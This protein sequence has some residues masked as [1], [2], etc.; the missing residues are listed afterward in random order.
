MNKENR[1]QSGRV[2]TLK[3]TDVSTVAP[4]LLNP[5]RQKGGA[6]SVDEIGIDMP[7]V[8]TQGHGAGKSCRMYD[9]AGGRGSSPTGKAAGFIQ[10]HHPGVVSLFER[11]P[12]DEAYGSFGAEIKSFRS[13]IQRSQ[14][15]RLPFSPHTSQDSCLT[16]ES[17]KFLH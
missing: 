12:T 7:S 14:N 2:I 9:E 3:G 1:V 4:L 5:S 13:H 11:H 16:G 15:T 17:I 6:P 8:Q 10:A